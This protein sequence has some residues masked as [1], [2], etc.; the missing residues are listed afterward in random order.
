MQKPALTIFFDHNRIVTKIVVEGTSENELP[1][2]GDELSRCCG[3]RVACAKKCTATKFCFQPCGEIK[4]SRKAKTKKFLSEVTGGFFGAIHIKPDIVAHKKRILINRLKTELA[5][6]NSVKNKMSI[7]A[8]INY[9][10]L[11]GWDG[12]CD[13]EYCDNEVTVADVIKNLSLECPT[14][15][16]K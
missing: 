5:L 14:C 16:Q 9:L 15:L 13:N 3:H 11:E 10:D 4:I 1:F 7:F 12:K 8:M 6:V 2:L